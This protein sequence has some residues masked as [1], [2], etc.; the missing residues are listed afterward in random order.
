MKFVIAALIGVVTGV[1]AGFQGIA[2]S[3]YILTLLLITGLSA[4]QHHAAGTT[5]LTVVFPLSI[6][7]VWEYYGRGEVDVPLALTIVAFYSF[8]ALEGAKLNGLV[9]QKFTYLSIALMMVLSSTY[10]F[11]RYSIE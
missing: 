6:G 10:Y 7:A 2:G 4:N 3:F 8:A 9:E 1:I 11:Y 5:L